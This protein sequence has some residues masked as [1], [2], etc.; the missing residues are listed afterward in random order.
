VEQRWKWIT[1]GSVFAVLGTIAVSLGF[2]FYVNNFGSYNKT[3]GSIG[4]VIVLLTWLYLTG[5]MILVGGEINAEIERAA[6]EGK[7]PGA[8]TAGWLTITDTIQAAGLRL[9]ASRLTLGA[10]GSQTAAWAHTLCQCATP[11]CHNVL[12]R[13][14]YSL[15]RAMSAPVGRRATFHRGHV[16]CRVPWGTRR[17]AT[18]AGGEERVDAGDA[19]R[20]GRWPWA[21]PCNSWKGKA[22][23]HSQ[24]V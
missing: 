15:R 18:G 4:A 23:G 9:N 24:G 8:K 11:S 1:P 21:V 12:P 6:P 19:F 14:G 2:S 16:L 20:Q 3:Y 5:L 22:V 7:A 13:D 17:G 10:P